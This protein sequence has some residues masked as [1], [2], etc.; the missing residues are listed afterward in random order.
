MEITGDQRVKNHENKRMS[1]V[2]VNIK[3]IRCRKYANT[4]YCRHMVDF[5]FPLLLLRF[6]KL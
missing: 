4:D 1:H 5:V 2:A 3:A 6:I